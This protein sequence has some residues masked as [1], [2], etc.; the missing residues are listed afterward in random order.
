MS[1]R[2]FFSFLL[3]LFTSVVFS[4]FAHE[5]NDDAV[6]LFHS[7]QDRSV[8]LIVLVSIS[9]SFLV[10]IALLYGSS[11]TE[12]LK[13][14]LFLGISIPVVFVTFYA[15]GATVYQNHISETKGPVHWHADF[16]IWNCGEQVNLL[17]P[18]GLTNRI[19]TPLFHEHNDAR[20]HVE[21]TLRAKEDVSL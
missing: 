12:P 6:Q 5:E 15:A 4:V 1:R 2:M 19:G 18:T 11:L 7:L 9:S 3:V 20:I 14:F 21:G 8:S 17:D 16:E 10:I 13:W